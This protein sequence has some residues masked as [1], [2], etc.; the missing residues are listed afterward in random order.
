MCW[1]FFI[2]TF[3]CIFFPFIFYFYIILFYTCSWICFPVP[4]HAQ[5]WQGEFVWTHKNGFQAPDPFLI[6]AFYKVQP[7][8]RLD[9]TKCN[10]KCWKCKKK[11]LT[12][13]N[14]CFGVEKL[15]GGKKTSGKGLGRHVPEITANGLF[16][17]QGSSSRGEKQGCCQGW[18][19]WVWWA[20][21]QWLAGGSGRCGQAAKVS[22]QV[23]RAYP[24]MQGWWGG[25]GTLQAAPHAGGELG[26]LPDSSPAPWGLILHTVKITAMVCSQTPV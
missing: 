26:M 23:P 11:I 7:D 15:T 9:K 1:A 2:Y 6:T 17:R 22:A 5:R 12:G 21:L 13:E 4:E 19:E 25:S 20:C 3:P 24:A 18:K 16:W 8:E 14:S 10:R